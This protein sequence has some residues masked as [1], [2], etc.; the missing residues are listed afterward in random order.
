MAR[1]R[2]TLQG[3]RGPTSRLGHSSSGLITTTNGWNIGLSAWIHPLKESP[4]LDSISLEMT[5]GSSGFHSFDIGTITE[6]PNGPVFTPSVEVRLHIINAFRA[7]P[8]FKK[9]I[10]E[11][12]T[13]GAI[14]HDNVPTD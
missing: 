6:T 1:Y 11:A 5:G 10:K 12:Y 14:Y 2:G 3:S 4:D 9:L 8:E 13:D 7:S